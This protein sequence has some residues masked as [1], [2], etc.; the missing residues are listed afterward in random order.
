MMVS[1]TL[2]TS[3]HSRKVITADVWTESDEV[4]ENLEYMLKPYLLYEEPITWADM[5]ENRAIDGYEPFYGIL[6]R[7]L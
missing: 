5:T 6:K 7:R 4:A 3:T 2:L 1:L